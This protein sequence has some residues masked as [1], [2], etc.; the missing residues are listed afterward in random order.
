M[1]DAMT[2]SE[3]AAYLQR[4]P[5]TLYRWMAMGRLP[6]HQDDSGRR[7]IDRDSVI[8]MAPTLSRQQPR[9]DSDMAAIQASLLRI[10]QR[11]DQQRSLLETLIAI[12]PVNSLD[13]LHRKQAARETLR[14]RS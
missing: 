13:Q 1:T 4:S 2:V 9:H 10:E 6:F 12:G 5:R 3:A 11:L 8:A 7:A 14:G